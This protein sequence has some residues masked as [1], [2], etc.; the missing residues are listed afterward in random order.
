MIWNKTQVNEQ[1]RT[2][3]KSLLS[4]QRKDTQILCIL[5]H[6]FKIF[7]SIYIGKRQTTKT[8]HVC[9]Q[10]FVLLGIYAYIKYTQMRV[11]TTTNPT[12]ENTF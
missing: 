7:I 2:D 9:Y 12:A 3:N 11:L 8:R 5:V 4:P 10:Y 1:P 6:L